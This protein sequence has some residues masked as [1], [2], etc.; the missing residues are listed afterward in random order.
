VVFTSTLAIFKQLFFRSC[1]LAGNDFFVAPPELV[2]AEIA[3]RNT[4]SDLGPKLEARAPVTWYDTLAGGQ[5]GRLRSYRLLSADIRRAKDAKGQRLAP[6][7][8]AAQTR[9]PIWDLEQNLLRPSLSDNP[10]LATLLTH[11]HLWSEEKQRCMLGVEKFLAQG[12]P[13]QLGV[14]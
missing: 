11:G 8:P 1:V 4:D 6:A 13:S 2:E 3:R 5:Q 14:A 12:I 7:P 10:L 9:N